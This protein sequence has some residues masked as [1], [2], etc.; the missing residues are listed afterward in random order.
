[1]S[2][3]HKPFLSFPLVIGQTCSGKTS[4]QVQ[5]IADAITKK[6]TRVKIPNQQKKK[7]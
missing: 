4:V 2:D 3:N 6:N 1:M 7:K 5:I